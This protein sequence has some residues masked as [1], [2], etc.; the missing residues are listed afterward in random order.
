[1]KTIFASRFFILAAAILF[2]F[3]VFA[4]SAPASV[5]NSKPSTT[6][7][8]SLVHYIYLANV[9]TRQDVLDL[10]NNIQ[11]QP[12]VTFFMAER[13]PVRCFVLK[14]TKAIS[15]ETFQTWVG[16]KYPV[17][18]FGMGNLAKEQAYIQYK[19]NRKSTH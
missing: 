10:E 12:D 14:S 16:Q 19:K 1:M 3:S 7:I 9:A 4:Q 5:K 2:S 6:A 18:T 8:N 13:Y 15:K 11:H 17:V